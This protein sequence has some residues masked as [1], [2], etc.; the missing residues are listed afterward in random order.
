M[1]KMFF[2]SLIALCSG[3]SYAQ[4]YVTGSV[5]EASYRPL[6][7]TAYRSHDIS[8]TGTVGYQINSNVGVSIGAFNGGY[9]QIRGLQTKVRG[10]LAAVFLN[11]PI[12]GQ[13]YAIAAVGASMSHIHNQKGHNTIVQPAF[14]AGIGYRMTDNVDAN[15][16]ISNSGGRFLGLDP[17]MDV[18]SVSTG[19]RYFFR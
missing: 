17:K 7:T 19:L 4:F 14:A 6:A 12:A 5:G 1:F 8:Y 10:E 18:V 3:A 13:Y 11:H 9:Y 2:A 16:I 15:L